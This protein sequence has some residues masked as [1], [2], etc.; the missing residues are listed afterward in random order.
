MFRF[1]YG[2]VLKLLH[3]V[4]G[5]STKEEMIRSNQ[6]I[7]SFGTFEYLNRSQQSQMNLR[8]KKLSQTPL[9]YTDLTQSSATTMKQWIQKWN[10]LPM[11][12]RPQSSFN[13]LNHFIYEKKNSVYIHLDASQ[14]ML[15]PLILFLFFFSIHF[16]YYT[17]NRKRLWEE[18]EATIQTSELHEYQTSSELIESSPWRELINNR[19]DIAYTPFFFLLNFLFLAV[20]VEKKEFELNA[21]EKKKRCLCLSHRI[22][23][24]ATRTNDFEKVA[25]THFNKSFRLKKK[26]KRKM[27]LIP[28]CK[29]LDDCTNENVD[30]YH[31]FDTIVLMKNTKT[32]TTTRLAFFSFHFFVSCISWIPS[33]PFTHAHPHHMM[34]SD[35]RQKINNR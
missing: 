18:W 24:T 25:F 4:F 13:T 11:I 8:K 23:P 20:A 33:V 21:W 32:W 9:T 5:L 35:R 14:L 10:F 22:A 27:N 28:M 2:S 19:Q 3:Q 6:D 31:I 1:C 15:F 26:K 30:V 17:D 34:I 7:W 12:Q 16:F 29:L